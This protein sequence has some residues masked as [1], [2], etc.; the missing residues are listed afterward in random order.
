MPKA[1]AID[2]GERCGWATAEYTDSAVDLL[3]S[4]IAPLQT[5]ALRLGESIGEYDVMIYESWR[6][7]PDKAREQIGSEM[8]TSQMIGIIRYL[9]WINDVELVR[10]DPA[11]KKTANKVARGEFADL[12]AR[13]PKTHDDAHNVDAV[14]HLY[15]WWW[16]T[17]IKE[18]LNAK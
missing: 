9:A 7:F 5:M 17:N 13:E 8:Q 12:I 10:Q 4:G 14:R 1:L 2:P 16:N 3:D 11:I 18:K 15:Y 6:L